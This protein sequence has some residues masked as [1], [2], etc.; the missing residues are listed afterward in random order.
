M[1]LICVDLQNAEAEI[2]LVIVLQDV[3][4]NC[5][6]RKSRGRTLLGTPYTIMLFLPSYHLKKGYLVCLLTNND[7]RKLRFNWLF[8]WFWFPI[9][10]SLNLHYGN[11]VLGNSYTC[12]VRKY[13]PRVQR[14]K[15]T[16]YSYKV[17]ACEL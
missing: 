11:P 17:R 1:F 15:G 9:A 13:V 3:S 6:K 14:Y 8:G 5:L 2:I 16:L 12:N 7:C 10:L 4:K